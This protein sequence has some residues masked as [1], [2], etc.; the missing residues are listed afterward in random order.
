MDRAPGYGP[1]CGGS[2]APGRTLSARRAGAALMMWPDAAR[3][4]YRHRPTGRPARVPVR[5]FRTRAGRLQGAGDAQRRLPA[6]LESTAARMG[7]GG[8]LTAG[9]DV[10]T[11]ARP[12]P[13][14]PL[15][16]GALERNSGGPLSGGPVRESLSPDGALAAGRRSL[17]CGWLD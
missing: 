15:P 13:A 2:N 5:R 6:T 11:G 7:T 12:L 16:T 3:G 14:L 4:A 10:L 8:G 17:R 9:P 1:G